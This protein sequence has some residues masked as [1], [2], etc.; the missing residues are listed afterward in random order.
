MNRYLK[1]SFMPAVTLIA[2]A[3]GFLL[4]LWLVLAGTDERGLLVTTHP[5]HILV[6][7]LTALVLGALLLLVHPLD[8]MKRYQ[9]LFPNGTLSCAGCIVAAAG[10]IWASLRERNL[11]TDTVTTV[12]LILGVLAAVCLIVIAVCRFRQQRPAYYFHTVITLF[13]MVHLVSQY[14]LWSSE[15]QLQVY[16]FPLLSSVFLM[17]TAYHSAVLDAK[18]SSRRWFVFCNQA[19]LFFCCVSVM[20]ELWPFYLA[21]AFWMFSGLCSLN[22]RPSEAPEEAQ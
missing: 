12:C 4:R 6:F 10:I 13:L 3:V 19:A 8:A 22:T 2:G 9:N 1:P 11:R 20:S 7:V 15:P 18:K 17:L 14:R 21:M 16:F 5:A